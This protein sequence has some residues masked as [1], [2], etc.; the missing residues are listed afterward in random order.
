MRKTVFQAG[1]ALLL[2]ALLAAPALADSFKA[3]IFCRLEHQ[4]LP[5]GQVKIEGKG[6]LHVT[7][8]GLTPNTTYHCDLE[9]E[10]FGPDFIHECAT[11][12]H[13]E[14]D[15]TF[16]KAVEVCIG[17]V[18]EIEVGEGSEEILDCGAGFVTPSLLP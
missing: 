7:V 15:V 5:T 16:K 8:T 17:P 1:S 4:H 13:G 3:D 6:N 2:S 18:F 12:D 9:C 10:L 11:D 14:I